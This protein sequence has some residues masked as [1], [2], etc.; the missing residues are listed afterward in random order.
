V[1][2]ERLRTAAFAVSADL[3]LANGEIEQAERR[4]LERLA[5]ELGLDRRTRDG[6]VQAMLVKNA[7]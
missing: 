6:L 4:F 2:L 7:A 5:S 3:V 1:V